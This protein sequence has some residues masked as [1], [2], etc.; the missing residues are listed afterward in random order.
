MQLDYLLFDFTDE[1]SGS[2]SFDA[3]ASVLPAKLPA[4]IHEIEAVLGWACREFG[5]P[6]AAADEGEWDFELQALGEQDVPLEITYDVERARVSVQQGLR[7]RV[8]LALTLSGSHA[9]GAAFREAFPDS[10]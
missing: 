7:G 3:M 10:D 4:L 1:E 9:F 8:T 6:S 5:A 2:C